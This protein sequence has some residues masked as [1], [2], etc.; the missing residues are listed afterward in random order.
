[1]I[2][3]IFFLGKHVTIKSLKEIVSIGNTSLSIV[4]K[5]IGFKYKKDE[6]R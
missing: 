6:E 2:D 5:E 3:H 1:M 4:L